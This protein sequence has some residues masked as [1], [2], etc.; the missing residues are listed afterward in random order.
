MTNSPTL[1]EHCTKTERRAE[2]AEREL[3]KIKLLTYLAQHIG[4]KYHAVIIG[5][6]DFGFFARLVEI[7]AEGLVHINR[8]GGRLL[9][10][11]ARDPHP[12]RTQGG[13]TLPPWRP[14]RGHHRPRRPRP[15]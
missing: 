5:V 7:P 9:L 14:D 2:T 3:I 11:R 8:P 10:P 15:A 13:E 4:E 12:D 6:E 1:A